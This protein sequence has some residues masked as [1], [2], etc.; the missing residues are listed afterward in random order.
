MRL[1]PLDRPPTLLAR[2]AHWVMRRQLGVVIAPAR[3]VFDRWPRLYPL[4]WWLLRL[5]QTRG[6]LDRPL[7]HL[8]QNHVARVNGCAFC[9]DIGR[10]GALIER[11][12]LEKLDALPEWRTSPLFDD[13]E[14]AALAYVEEATREKRV[15]DATFDRI[16][17][18]FSDREIVELTVLNAI[19]NFYNLINLPLEI[20]ADGLCA[21][22]ERRLARA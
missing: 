17:K 18:H 1:E 7:R 15:S 16:R 20:E 8:V 14:R 10:A 4:E 21:I 13:R 3:V 19:E 22:Q 6:A 5:Q 12:G 11:V 9:V 2:L